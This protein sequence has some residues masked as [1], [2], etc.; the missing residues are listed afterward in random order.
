MPSNSPIA[1][2][3]DFDETLLSISSAGIGFKVLK[4]QGYL[5]RTFMLKMAVT[6]LLLK[7]GL[8]DEEAMAKVFLG[9]YKGRDI[10]ALVDSSPDF[11]RVYLKP[12]LAQQVV[13][14]LKW[15]QSQGHQTVLVTGSI[16]Y[17]LTPVM[18]DLGIDHLLCTHLEKDADGI[19]TGRSEGPI[20]VGEQ[21]V[22]LA[23]D[24]AQAQGIDLK[25]SYAY[26]NSELD[27]P[28]L[29]KV[30]HPVSVNPSQKLRDHARA[31]GWPE[32]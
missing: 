8:I 28:I 1:A 26:G 16:D 11:Y 31:H 30:G 21:K 10:Q 2:F 14:K 20:C 3:F 18:D 17:Y 13:E 22:K 4:E 7:L 23:L 5:S 9:F 29:E 15:H 27:I 19:P 24:L 25:E 32:L 12:N 6:H